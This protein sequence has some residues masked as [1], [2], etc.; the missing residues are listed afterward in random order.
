MTRTLLFCLNEF[1]GGNCLGTLI[2][3]LCFIVPQS[4]FNHDFLWKYPESFVPRIKHVHIPEFN[5]NEVSQIIVEVEFNNT[6]EE[7]G[8][9]LVFPHEEFPNVL[10]LQVEA[11][12]RG[13]TCLPTVK[14]QPKPVN[15]GVLPPGKYKIVDF[16]NLETHYGD[17]KVHKAKTSGSFAKIGHLAVE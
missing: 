4:F 16:R 1:R 3:S 15:I 9:T 11:R 8:R 12:R 13:E 7:Y 6:C 17:L 10:L 5:N 2:F 14:R